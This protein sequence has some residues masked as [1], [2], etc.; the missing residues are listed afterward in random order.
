MLQAV[1][2]TDSLE[3][4]EELEAED[5]ALLDRSV[6]VVAADEVTV[7]VMVVA[8]VVRATVE[9]AEELGTAEVDDWVTVDVAGAV[10]DDA[11][12]V[13]EEEAGGPGTNKVTPSPRNP[14]SAIAT[15]TPSNVRLLN[16]MR[17]SRWFV[18]AFSPIFRTKEERGETSGG[19]FHRSKEA[20]DPPAEGCSFGRS[21]GHSVPISESSA[22]SS[23]FL[24]LIVQIRTIAPTDSRACT[25]RVRLLP[26]PARI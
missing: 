7:T 11:T 14:A 25:V 26:F 6:V 23:R 1:E 9:L 10:D 17:S 12:E 4:R 16:V 18:L 5:D 13:V 15:M 19:G 20:S 22:D 24:S 3:L 8:D 21:G 2:L